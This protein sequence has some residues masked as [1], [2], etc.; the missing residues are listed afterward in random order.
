MFFL[1]LGFF[2]SF[3]EVIVIKVQIVLIISCLFLISFLVFVHISGFF[4]SVFDFYLIYKTTKIISV[5]F[6]PSVCLLTFSF[7]L[8]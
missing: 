3:V 5:F 1:V 7:W 4:V 6:L 8:L 2:S